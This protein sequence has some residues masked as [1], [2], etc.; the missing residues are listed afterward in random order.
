MRRW[1]KSE[2]KVTRLRNHRVFSLRCKDEK[3]TPVFLKLSS[4][5]RSPKA[6]EIL[7]R[8]EMQL[9]RVNIRNVTRKI[10]DLEQ[11]IEKQKEKIRDKIDEISFRQVHEYSKRARD[12]THAQTK[13]K[14]R[15]KFESLVGKI[16]IQKKTTTLNRKTSKMVGH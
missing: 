13:Q 14:Q 8:T 3:V 6:S 1:T 7:K 4:N 5:M 11:D 9:L 10:G 2:E 16:R 12:Y 15:K